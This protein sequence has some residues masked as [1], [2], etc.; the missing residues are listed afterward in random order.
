MATQE[1]VI[2]IIPGVSAPLIIHC[3]YG[4]KGTKITLDVYNYSEPYDCT[5]QTV[6]VH[7][8]RA[9]SF[10][11]GPVPCTVNK[12]KISFVLTSDM[13]G[14]AGPGLAEVTIGTVSTANFC[15]MV[16]RGATEPHRKMIYLFIRPF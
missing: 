15:F 14:C 4:D 9:D 2:N 16:E 13:T 3:S 11:W 8:V 7:G 12:N 10:N 5:G 1:H 6:S